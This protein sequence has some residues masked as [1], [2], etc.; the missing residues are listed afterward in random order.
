MDHALLLRSMTLFYMYIRTYE[1]MVLDIGLSGFVFVFVE[2]ACV[3]QNPGYGGRLRFF[4]SSFLFFFFVSLEYIEHSDQEWVSISISGCI[5]II[6][7]IL[8]FSEAS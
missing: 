6:I 1:R 2:Q 7:L 8:Y 3:V 5:I 4:F